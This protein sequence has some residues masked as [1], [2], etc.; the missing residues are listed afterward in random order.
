MRLADVGDDTDCR[1]DDF[2]KRFNLSEPAH[3]DFDDGSVMF[4][5]ETEQSHRD[6]DL[7]VEVA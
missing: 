6:A 2:G 1:A 5:V 4:L 7:V 3:S